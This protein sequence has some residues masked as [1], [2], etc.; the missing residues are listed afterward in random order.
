M[1]GG[2]EGLFSLSYVSQA[3]Q[4]DPT[5]LLTEAASIAAT[6]AARNAEGCVT[7]A[8]AV[9]DGWF[10]Q[11]MEG[12]RSALLDTFDRILRDPRP[13][14]IRLLS[15]DPIA[16]RHFADWSMGFSGELEPGLLSATAAEHARQESFGGGEVA[17]RNRAVLAALALPL[18][19]D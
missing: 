13:T 15:F 2:E 11:V 16:R 19:A 1:R 14:K 6:S 7:G 10:A 4:R 17:Q 3:T 5:A 12:R 8:L 18:G 9:G